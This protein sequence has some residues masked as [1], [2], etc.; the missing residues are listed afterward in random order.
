MKVSRWNQ[1]W[2]LFLIRT[3]RNVR[4]MDG[5]GF[6]HVMA[7]LLG[8]ARRHGED[9]RDV[10]RRHV[11]YFNAN[12][13]LAS[14]I[15]GVVTNM[16]ERRY[17]GEEVP[18]ERIEQ[19]KGTLA[20]VLTARGDY[21][22]GVR[23]G[24]GIGREFVT[25]VFREQRLLGGCAA[26]VSGLFAALIVSRASERGGLILVGWGILA[27]AAMFALVRKVSFLWSVVIVFIA[28]GLFLMIM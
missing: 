27:A 26:F 14:Y 2:R 3:S 9:A 10:A 28:T 7:P 1:L 4:L 23:M 5:I 18:P 6:F 12:S 25:R 11:S 22:K 13:I 24:E 21:F 20:S 8:A 19:V 16:E 15:A 17:A